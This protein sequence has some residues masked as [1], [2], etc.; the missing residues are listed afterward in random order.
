MGITVQ[1]EIALKAVERLQRRMFSTVGNELTKKVRVLRS[2]KG[3][4]VAVI[5]TNKALTVVTEPAYT[6]ATKIAGR[7]KR[8]YA[9]TDSRNSNLN[10]GGSKLGVG[11]S[12]DYWVFASTAD[13]DKFCDWYSL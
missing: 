4:H 9:P 7:H 8:R 1:Q 5:L 6:P 11:H 2:P 3:K 13:F 12:I 10:F